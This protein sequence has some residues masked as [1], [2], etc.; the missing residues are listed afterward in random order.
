MRIFGLCA[1]KD[2]ADIL[3]HTLI[4]ASEWCDQIF[5]Y[6]NASSDGTLGLIRKLSRDYPIVLHASDDRDFSAW[7]QSYLYNSYKGEA[8]DGDWWCRL[9]ADELYVENPRIFLAKVP[10]KFQTVWSAH[11]QYQFTDRDLEQYKRSPERFSAR[12]HPTERF[13]YYRNDASELR[14]F[15]HTAHLE[16]PHGRAW[17]IGLGRPYPVRIWVRHF[18]Y[19]SPEQIMLRMRTR[20]AL[21]RRTG[22]ENFRH[23][24]RSLAGGVDLASD[25]IWRA[26]VA[27][28]TELEYDSHDGRLVVREDLMPPIGGTHPRLRTFARRLGL[29]RGMISRSAL[30]RHRRLEHA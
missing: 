18:Q 24:L 27:P 30:P 19:R 3:E 13:R 1:A 22:G 16:W 7:L 2:E 9:D 23:E 26:R 21:A 10:L 15:R 12:C 14:F 6:D 4:E 17:P 29:H 11:F 5:V 8:N 20:V 28:A 25:E